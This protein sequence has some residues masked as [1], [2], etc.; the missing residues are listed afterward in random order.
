MYTAAKRRLLL[1]LLLLLLFVSAA[2][3][4]WTRTAGSV[5][6]ETGSQQ[7]VEADVLHTAE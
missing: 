7:C 1:V 2:G 5:H 3:K 6:A 4:T